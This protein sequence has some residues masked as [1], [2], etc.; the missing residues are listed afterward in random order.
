MRLNIKMGFLKVNRQY[1]AAFC[2]AMIT[3]IVYMPALKNGF[4]NWDDNLYVYKNSYIQSLNMKL[5][6]WIPEVALWH[7]VTMLSLAIDYAIWKLEPF[8][9]HLTN[10]FLHALNTFLVY[11]ITIRLLSEHIRTNKKVL[12]IGFITSL[13]FGIHP[14]H[15]ESVAWISERKDVLC[16]LFFLSTVLLYL[17]FVFA[18][19]STKRYAYFSCAFLFFVLSLMSKPMAVSLPAILLLLDYYPLRR[20]YTNLKGVLIEKSPFFITSFIFSIITFVV[21][22]KEEALPGVELYPLKSRIQ[23]VI[24][25]YIFYIGKMILPFNFAPYYPSNPH[26]GST[27]FFVSGWL[28]LAI[29]ICITIWSL[30][31]RGLLFSVWFYYIITLIPVIGIIKVGLFSAA[32]RYS[33]LP[34]LG[35]FLFFGLGIGI[36]FDKFQGKKAIW[37]FMTLALL[38]VILAN[39]TTKQIRIWE[40]S[41]TLWS[42]QITLFP[43]Q[44]E[45][46]YFNRGLAYYAA[47]RYGDAIKDYTVA[48]DLNPLLIEARH[49]RGVAYLDTGNYSEALKDFDIIVNLNPQDYK[50]YHLRGY[51]HSMIGE[52]Q[53]ALV[54]LKRAIDLNPNDNIVYYDL[55][56]TY[57]Q[58]GDNPQATQNLNIAATLGSKEAQ[59]L[60]NKIMK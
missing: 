20:L 7:P 45:S 31:R 15:V 43:R 42:H 53:Q 44:V 57:L 24:Q 19:T 16:A 4:V 1:V 40:N 30:K 39:K 54:D 21:Q 6:Y 52:Y 3:F 23:I 29:L 13:L 50:P 17:N 47:G 14:I 49:N 11:V 9:Y 59:N 8:G 37:L 56:L 32:D 26:L 25:S 60:L 51:I 55:A 48:V 41:I 34:S 18:K 10:N 38:A 22:Q 35:I 5:F 36:L 28:S 46:V 12:I 33:Y 2:V 58:L 27:G